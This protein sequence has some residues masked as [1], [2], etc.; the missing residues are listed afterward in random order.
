M[1]P[2]MSDV[3]KALQPV[4]DPELDLS[5]VDMGLIR[6]VLV[7]AATGHAVVTMTL[8]SPYC[9]MGPQII[10]AARQAALAVDGVD[11]ADVD[12]VWEPPWNPRTDASEEVKAEL[13]IWD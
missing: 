12:M 11:E 13:G 3:L 5:I 2:T 6:D 4:K 1:N 8:T 9:P 7:D 10:E